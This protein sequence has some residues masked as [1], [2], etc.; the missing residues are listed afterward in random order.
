[1]LRGLS[2]Y[3][4]YIVIR[5]VKKNAISSPWKKNRRYLG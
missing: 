5:T 4:L 3:S 1:M 2:I